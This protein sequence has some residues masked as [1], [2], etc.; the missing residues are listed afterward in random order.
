MRIFIIKVRVC[1]FTR[2]GVCVNARARVCECACVWCTYALVCVCACV[3]ACECACV[4]ARKK[5]NEKGDMLE[6]QGDNVPQHGTFLC[7]RY[8]VLANG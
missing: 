5:G 8:F 6:N 1:A 3:R 2:I 4:C 7:Y